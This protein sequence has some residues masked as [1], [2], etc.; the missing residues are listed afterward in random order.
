MYKQNAP[1]PTAD[2]F[3]SVEA[4]ADQ[5]FNRISTLHPSEETPDPIEEALADLGE[6]AGDN[7]VPL[8][9]PKDPQQDPL[10]AKTEKLL[11]SFLNALDQTSAPQDADPK[12]TADYTHAPDIGYEAAYRRAQLPQGIE[13]LKPAAHATTDEDTTANI[14]AMMDEHEV[15]QEA[16][17]EQS[18]IAQ[19]REKARQALAT[20]E[21]QE[22]GAPRDAA[23]VQPYRTP[24]SHR[25][26]RALDGL[27]R[28]YY[29]LAIS[30]SGWS[31][32]AMMV[33]IEPAV[34]QVLGTLSMALLL[35][36]C[37][38]FSHKTARARTRAHLLALRQARA[39]EAQMHWS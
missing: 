6:D 11:S 34:S 32:L 20:L 14:R 2:R 24:L 10:L 16:A 30:L 31:T 19:R 17:R 26:V 35:V 4:L 8:F 18:R 21:P 33:L 28:N 23:P 13:P 37:C 39:D 36:A 9:A 7:V 15:A 12:R 22:G 5:I 1:D 3:N 27:F 38:M 29:F 25:V